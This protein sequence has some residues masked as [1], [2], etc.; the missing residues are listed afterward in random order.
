MDEFRNKETIH[1]DLRGVAI[2]IT[3]Y[4]FLVSGKTARGGWDDSVNGGSALNL[5]RDS[6]INRWL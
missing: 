1:I 2:T 6:R 4:T 3:F 5:Q